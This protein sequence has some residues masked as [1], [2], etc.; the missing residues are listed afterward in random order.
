MNYRIIT[1]G[2][3]HKKEFIKRLSVT[4]WLIIINLV[5]FLVSFALLLIYPNFLEYIALKPSNIIH[6]EKLW[7]LVTHMFM[8]HPFFIFH[9]LFN[10]LSLFF[11][12]NFLEKLIG[13]KRYFWFYIISGIFA[14]LIAVVC[15]YF[16][17]D[18][19][20]FGTGMDSSSVG[21]SG[22]IF[23]IAG[24][25]CF[26]TPNIKLYVMFIP[27]PIKAKYAVPGLL[28]LLALLS[29]SGG[30]PIGNAA[31]F[32]GFLAGMIYGIYL[33][34]KYPNKTKMIERYFS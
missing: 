29:V 19:L 8:H 24:L 15:S 9:L 1:E 10:M 25:M 28:V 17:G 11:I 18:S 3:A 6:G 13:R 32:G 23:G 33:R 4:N 16:L 5:F 7:T 14:G 34:M 26:L 30:W 31:H 12:G 2:K 22:V 21:A 27:I 20:F